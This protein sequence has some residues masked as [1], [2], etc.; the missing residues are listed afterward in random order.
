MLL[1]HRVTIRSMYDPAIPGV[2]GQAGGYPI[3]S[4]RGPT[5]KWRT[6]F[7]ACLHAQSL[8]LP[9][10]EPLECVLVHS[11]NEAVVVNL[12]GIEPVE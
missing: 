9:R 3:P 8:N 11:N 6:Y 2:Y 10:S 4:V 5:R 1:P 7:L 12:P